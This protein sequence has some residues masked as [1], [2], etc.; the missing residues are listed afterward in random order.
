[1][2][3][4]RERHG[5]DK[6]SGE[7]FRAAVS[8]SGVYDGDTLYGVVIELPDN[9]APFGE[10]DD[11]IEVDGKMVPVPEI[12]KTGSKGARF[13]P[14]TGAIY[15]EGAT[16]RPAGYDAWEL[17]LDPA[18]PEGKYAKQALIRMFKGGWVDESVKKKFRFVVRG[19]GKI[20]GSNTGPVKGFWGR[21]VTDIFIVEDG[22][23]KHVGEM[24]L[25]NPIDEL[26]EGKHGVLTT[27]TDWRKAHERLPRGANVP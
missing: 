25:K 10:V 3:W 8:E 23:Q 21:I 1:M 2:T 11:F 9:M 12:W 17:N 5:W 7:F 26:S 22:K 16:I 20:R 15:M 14:R 13:N 4:E 18:G 19:V 24:I 27:P 6:I